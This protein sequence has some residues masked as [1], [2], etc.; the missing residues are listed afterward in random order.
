MAMVRPPELIVIGYWDDPATPGKWPRVEDFIDLSWDEDDRDFVGRYLQTGLVVAAYMGYSTCRVC[1]RTDN[2]DLELSDGK[3][4]WPNGLSHYVLNHGVR[5]P[6]W[7]VA[8]A[9][10][11]TETLEAAPRSTER[12]QSA[13]ITGSRGEP[14]TSAHRS[15][16]EIEGA[17]TVF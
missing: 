13:T 5:L 1:G 16:D 3:F 14:N 7:F 10:L 6:D 15:C 8:H 11:L 2:G 9:Y 12:W 4:V 17:R